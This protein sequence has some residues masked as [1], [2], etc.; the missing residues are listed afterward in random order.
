MHWDHRD[1]FSPIDQDFLIVQS[2]TAALDGTYYFGFIKKMLR[3]LLFCV[4]G[5][6]VSEIFKYH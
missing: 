6:Q 3:Q 5:S 4:D 2:F 1:V